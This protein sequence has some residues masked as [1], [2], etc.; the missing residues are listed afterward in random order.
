MIKCKRRGGT[1]DVSDNKGSNGSEKTKKKM[2]GREQEATRGGMLQIHSLN[3]D[4]VY[5]DLVYNQELTRACP[6]KFSSRDFFHDKNLA[7]VTSDVNNTGIFKHFPLS[8]ISIE[9]SFQKA[10]VSE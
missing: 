6:L 1:T 8:T 4:I 3:Y 9:T 7:C 5:V 2:R 10:M